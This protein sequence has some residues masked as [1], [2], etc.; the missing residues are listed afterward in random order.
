MIDTDYADDLM[1]LANTTAQ[2]E[3]LLQSLEQST[4]GIGLYVTQIKQSLC[5]LNENEPFPH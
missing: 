1:L 4:R 5:V 2:A 3:S